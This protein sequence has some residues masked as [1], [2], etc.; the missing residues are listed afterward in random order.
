MHC[1][2]RHF[3]V[4]PVSRGFLVYRW[5][6]LHE[7]AMI[8]FNEAAS[9]LLFGDTI[10]KTGPLLREKNANSTGYPIDLPSRGGG[11]ANKHHFGHA[12]GMSFGVSERQGRSPGPSK[13]QPPLDIEVPTQQFDIGEE[14]SCRVRGE[15]YVW[16]A[17]VR[18][19]S[20]RS[21][22]VEQN[23]P[24]DVWIKGRREPGEQPEPGPPWSTTAGLPDGFPHVSQ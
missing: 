21:A 6:E 24:I 18:R 10:T 13:Y 4:A 16:L 14:M 12:M 22:L 11:D 15:I 9:T 5:I 1:Y 19:A 17:R 20:S 3:P 23:D 2:E 7:E 8:G